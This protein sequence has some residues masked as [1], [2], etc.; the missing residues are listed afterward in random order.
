MVWP[1]KEPLTDIPGVCGVVDGSVKGGYYGIEAGQSAVGDIFLWYVNNLVPEQY[2]T[3][4]DEKFEN[5]E[6]AADKLRPGESG[7]LA[8]D[9][10]NGNGTILVDVRLLDY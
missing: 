4:I 6:A 10:N 2:G 8:L 7:L 5:L 3:S 9:W 1:N